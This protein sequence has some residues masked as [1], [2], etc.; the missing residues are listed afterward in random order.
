MA[1]SVWIAP[2]M[3][4]SVNDATARSTADTMPTE[5]DCAC[6]NGEP[7]AATGSPTRTASEDPNGSGSSSKPFGSTFSS[8]MSAFGSRPSTRASTRLPSANST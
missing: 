5:S 4:K 3:A 7:I 8:A 1:A 6:P 2:A